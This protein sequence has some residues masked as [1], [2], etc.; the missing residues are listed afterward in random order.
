MQDDLYIS[1]ILTESCMWLSCISSN[2]MPVSAFVTITARAIKHPG[3]LWRNQ[4][5][6]PVPQVWQHQGQDCSA[7]DPGCHVPGARRSQKGAAGLSALPEVR[8]RTY[9]LPGESDNSPWLVGFLYSPHWACN[10]LNNIKNFSTL[11]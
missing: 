3:T 7:R 4:R 11:L 10:A 6:R 8:R 1:H 9:P 5:H 2:T